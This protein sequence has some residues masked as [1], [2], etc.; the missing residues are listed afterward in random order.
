[1]FFKGSVCFEVNGLNLSPLADKLARSGVTLYAVKRRHR[2]LRFTVSCADRDKVIARLDNLCYNYTI[3]C[4][5]GILPVFGL[6]IKRAGILAGL[7]AFA[8]VLF[9]SGF[10]VWEIRVSGCQRIEPQSVL[11]KVQEAGVREKSFGR[12][13]CREIEKHLTTSFKD[14]AFVTARY[15][16]LA[17]FIEIVETPPRLEAID[18]APKD[19]VSHCDGVISRLLVFSGTP[20]VK[21]GDAV[22]KGQVIIAGYLEKPDGERLPVRAM[23]EV[24]GIARLS[25]IETYNCKVQVES[26]TGRVQEHRLIELF[27]ARFPAK[28]PETSFKSYKTETEYSYIFYNNFLPAKSVTVKYLET[29]IIT[30]YRD[31]EKVKKIV[32]EEARKNA[33]ER[34]AALGRVVKTETKVTGGGSVKYIQTIVEVEKSLI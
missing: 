9:A 32:T 20:L 22:K 25:Y 10:F 33:E 8:A 15:K 1:M 12:A 26:P 19:V 28:L 6:L 7:A 14:I 3:K 5:K 11:E 34:A 17:L 30:E 27:G 16:G 23:G 4:A 29:E 21:A 31:F 24:Y 18:N 2:L 13:D